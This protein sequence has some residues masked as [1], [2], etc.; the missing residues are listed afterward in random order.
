[1]TSYKTAYTAVSFGFECPIAV[2]FDRYAFERG[3]PRLFVLD[4]HRLIQVTLDPATFPRS[5]KS[6]TMSTPASRFKEFVATGTGH[7]AEF[8]F[9][10]ALEC[11][12]E[13]LSMIPGD[14][15]VLIR[16][17]DVHC[18]T[19]RFEAALIDANAALV[20]GCQ[21]SQAH[22]LRGRAL[23]ALG[24]H[25]EAVAALDRAAESK[26][27]DEPDTV[28]M[29][30]SLRQRSMAAKQMALEVNAAAQVESTRKTPRAASIAAESSSTADLMK[31]LEVAEAAERE[32][33]E[34]LK[35]ALSSLEAAQ[36]SSSPNSKSIRLSPSINPQWKTK[37][38]RVLGSTQEEIDFISS[39]DHAKLISSLELTHASIMAGTN[40]DG[41]ILDGDDA[42][43]QRL[44]I[45]ER[46]FALL[47]SQFITA[48]SEFAALRNELGYAASPAAVVTPSKR[49]SVRVRNRFSP[50]PRASIVKNSTPKSNS[51]Q[52]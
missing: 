25:D 14:A 16:R 1:V 37:V 34:Q 11:F 42:L 40:T 8:R 9:A 29:A 35:V 13:A 45:M 22:L 31:R 2:H 26:A 6:P 44:R 18:K 33:T 27:S 46:K 50:S 36:D 15:D 3:E 43:Q 5:S 24:R 48:H 7:A 41:A 49:N 28:Q 47:S 52:Q 10:D 38:E 17:G 4:A 32:R 20:G 12:N 51:D 39:V 19:G 30:R 21:L 23:L